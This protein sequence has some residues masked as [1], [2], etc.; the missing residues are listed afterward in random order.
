MGHYFLGIQYLL[1]EERDARM[2]SQ[3][4]WKVFQAA[5]DM[6]ENKQTKK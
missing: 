2:K 1:G 5:Q 6:I 3:Q 4:G